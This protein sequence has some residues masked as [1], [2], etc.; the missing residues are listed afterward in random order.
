ME[1]LHKDR[2]R[3]QLVHS[4]R[5]RYKHILV[6]YQGSEGKLH[7]HSDAWI[8]QSDTETLSPVAVL[9]VYMYVK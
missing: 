3:A 6:P 7:I 2:N 9:V 8:S 1:R 4:T 5:D